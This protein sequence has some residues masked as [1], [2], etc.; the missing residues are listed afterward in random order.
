MAGQTVI[1]TVSAPCGHDGPPASL[2]VGDGTRDG[3]SRED[4]GFDSR[5]RH[6]SAL[7]WKYVPLLDLPTRRRS[8]PPSPEIFAPRRDDCGNLGA[9]PSAES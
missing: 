3:L 4:D 8:V 1:R 6:L 9:E 5:L 7:A 2:T